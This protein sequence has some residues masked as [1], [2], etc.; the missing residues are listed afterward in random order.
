LAELGDTIAL[1]AGVPIELV[2]KVSGHQSVT[3]LLAH[4]FKPGRDDL[5]RVLPEK[6]PRMFL[7]GSAA[8][9]RVDA[10]KRTFADRLKTM[11]AE[12][13]TMIRDEL[14]AELDGECGSK[15]REVVLLK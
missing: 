14:I 11:T 7:V 6:M 12:N 13:W 15:G 9:P 4:Y 10:V 2:K 1:I 5:R 8:S 3:V